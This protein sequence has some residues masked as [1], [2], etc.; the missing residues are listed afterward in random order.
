MV[1]TRWMV[2]VHLLDKEKEKLGWYSASV[3]VC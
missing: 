1:V 3:L 2:E